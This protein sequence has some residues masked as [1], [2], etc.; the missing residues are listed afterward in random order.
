[1]RCLALADEYI[2]EASNKAKEPGAVGGRVEI[3]RRMVADSEWVR[4]K[5]VLRGP[6]W[7]VFLHS[8]AYGHTMAEFLLIRGLI[9]ILCER[10][11]TQG[12]DSSAAGLV[13]SL[14]PFRGVA[15]AVLA[16]VYKQQPTN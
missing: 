1:M 14:K 10:A 13:E 6:D 5:Q 2:S 9:D 12:G 16:R 7:R 3:P 11:R 15:S 4:N 8:C